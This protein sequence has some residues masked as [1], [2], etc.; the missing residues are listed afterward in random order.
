MDERETKGVRTILNFGHTL[1]HAI[2]AAA[3]YKHYHH[4]EAVALGMRIA[5]S[6]SCQMGLLQK[7]SALQV[8]DLMT[9]I[10]LPKR[11]EHL[12]LKDI[13]A[14]MSHDKKFQAGKNKF[15]LATG[16][17]SVKVVE[18]VPLSIIKNAVLRFLK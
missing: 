13:L 3:Q 4:G 9:T 10:G 6:I 7:G 2:E 14:K 1:G 18:D 17:G 16:I 11:I 15:V 5:L 8:E 12:S